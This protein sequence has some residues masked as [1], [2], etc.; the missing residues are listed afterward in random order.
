MYNDVD[1]VDEDDGD[2]P[3]HQLVAQQ[4]ALEEF[5]R[6]QKKRRK[7]EREQAQAQELEDNDLAQ[8]LAESSEEWQRQSQSLNERATHRQHPFSEEEENLVSAL[9]LSEV[10]YAQQESISLEEEVL[11][12]RHN[13]A[14]EQNQGKWDCPK[15]TYENRP[16]APSCSMCQEQ[17]PPS[18][19]TFC[20]MAPL[21]YGVEMEIVV[22]NGALDGYSL[23]D[24]AKNLTDLGTKVEFM[25]YTHQTCNHWKLVTDA[26]I[27][28]SDNDIGFELVSPILQGER[29]LRSIRSVL[30]NVR[31]LGI[32]TNKSCGFHVHVDASRGEEQE[33]EGMKSLKGLRQIAKAFVALENAF[34]LLVSFS[35]TRRADKSEY[36]KSNRL[37]FG[38]MS[39][40]QRWDCLCEVRNRQELVDLLNPGQDRYRKLNLTNL[41]KPNRP[42]TIE[43]RNHGG[44]EELLETEAW[45]RLI[46]RFCE[47]VTQT[48]TASAG[49]ALLAEN[50]TPRGELEVL[51]DLLDCDGLEQ[52]YVVERR[53]FRGKKLSNSWNCKVCR[54]RFSDSRSLAQ[55]TSMTGHSA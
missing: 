6:N 1:Q 18:T 44:V 46:V 36:C 14:R 12:H 39:N 54:K 52:F 4:S 42:S 3:L 2:F 50:T 26:S 30:E 37:A 47:Q 34:D 45:V 11:K 5:E 22:P 51:F 27:S 28:A 23:E 35:S 43:F 19:L 13:R 17:A 7:R 25:G 33:M 10:E 24:I 48:E 9:Q 21:R 20:P 8:A 49:R 53:L 31:S 40:R 32:E 55:H 38:S 41:V 29:G 16:Y 15:C